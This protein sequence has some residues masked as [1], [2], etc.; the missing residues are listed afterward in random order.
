MGLYRFMHM[1]R[2]LLLGAV[3]L[4]L[5]AL[6]SIW[7]LP[8]SIAF[9]AAGGLLYWYLRGR[10]YFR[11]PS[12]SSDAVH[13][14]D[15]ELE[16]RYL[17]TQVLRTLTRAE[18]AYLTQEFD[19]HKEARRWLRNALP[20]SYRGAVDLLHEQLEQ[21]RAGEPPDSMDLVVK[22]MDKRHELLRLT[23]ALDRVHDDHP[24][25]VKANP[26]IFVITESIS[27]EGADPLVV[28]LAGCN[29]DER[30][31]MP[32]VDAVTFFTE[33]EGERQIRGQSDFDGARAALSEHW[34]R[35]NAREPVYLAGPVQDPVKLGVQLSKVPLGFVIGGAEL[36]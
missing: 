30:T 32:E 17:V 29:T 26:V 2:N 10:G 35:V 14:G 8:G 25:H 28:T 11:L 22:V 4:A 5:S 13:G 15:R 16:A 24:D 18:V 36:V 20:R 34:K 3:W 7:S 6:I 21:V 23:D 1:L 27:S 12:P 31:L 33:Q 19:G 9:L